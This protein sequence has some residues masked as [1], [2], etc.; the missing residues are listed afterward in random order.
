V[1]V[2]ARGA[3]DPLRPWDSTAREGVGLSRPSS[4]LRLRAVAFIEAPESAPDRADALFDAIAP[5]GGEP[6]QRVQRLIVAAFDSAARALAFASA[7]P[8]E[9][10]AGLS[11]GDVL[12][13]GDA[14]HG[15]P[16]IEASRLREKAQWGQILCAA[17]LVAL[18]P[19]AATAFR[20]AGPTLLEGFAE[21]LETYECVSRRPSAREAAARGP[22]AR[23]ARAAS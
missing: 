6:I 9:L 3:P 7:L 11:V 13:E 17:D 22:R 20:S 12:F 1:T 5:A 18:A 16:V 21:A 14:I 4:R 10:R 8:S 15:L 19:E 23:A 2:A